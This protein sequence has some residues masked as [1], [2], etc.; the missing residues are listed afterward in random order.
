MSE[1][2]MVKAPTRQELVA[3]LRVAQGARYLVECVIAGVRP[4]PDRFIDLCRDM[5]E[6]EVNVVGGDIEERAVSVDEEL[7][8]YESPLIAAPA[9]GEK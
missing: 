9:R 1:A 6:L 7:E 2:R 8:G 5:F 3:A 4:D